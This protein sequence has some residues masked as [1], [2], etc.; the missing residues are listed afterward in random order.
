[1]TNNYC[2]MVNLY[3]YEHY[4]NKNITAYNTDNKVHLFVTL[5]AISSCTLDSFVM[6]VTRPRQ[7]LHLNFVYLD[8]FSTPDQHCTATLVMLIKLC[9]RTAKSA[10]W[11]VHSG[12]VPGPC[13]KDRFVVTTSI[14]KPTQTHFIAGP[15]V[16]MCAKKLA[17]RHNLI[18]F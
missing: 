14:F 10:P 13:L 9:T 4:L 5:F 18:N 6:R 7:C 1:M 3:I 11:F 16:K 8:L 15:L 12:C 2:L 17:S